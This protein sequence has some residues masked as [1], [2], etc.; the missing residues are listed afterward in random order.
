[1]SDNYPQPEIKLPSNAVAGDQSDYWVELGDQR[2]SK[3]Q[4]ELIQLYAEGYHRAQ[5]H[6]EKPTPMEYV[7]RAQQ[8]RARQIEKGYDAKHDDRQGLD[9][10]LAEAQGYHIDGDDK[11]LSGLLQAARELLVR[12]PH[13]TAHSASMQDMV[14]AFHEGMGQPVGTSP[15]PLPEDR[16]A[17]RIELIREEFIDELIP[18]LGAH[19]SFA[20]DGRTKM[21]Y[22]AASEQDVVE[23]ADAAIDILYVV[24]GLLVEMG[25]DAYPLFAEVQRSNMSKFGA[26][27]K[28]II[29][30]PN[31]PDG[32]FEGRV[33]KGPNYFQPNLKMPLMEQGWVQPTD[34]QQVDHGGW[35]DH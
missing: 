9:H 6:Y 17:V 34:A 7:V 15:R 27:G 4:W 23:V 5:E 21:H 16:V 28:A 11:A 32:I 30:G 8:E 25:I 22:I 3:H 1:M 31:D 19:M 26:D 10:L 29:A 33:K 24:F 12:H 35:E 14:R 20:P 18:A 2:F 13:S